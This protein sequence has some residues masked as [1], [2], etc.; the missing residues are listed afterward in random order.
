[1]FVPPPKNPP[2]GPEAASV[3]VSTK[4]II[5][6]Q[7]ITVIDHLSQEQGIPATEHL[8][9]EQSIPDTE[10]LSQ[11]QGIS[12]AEHLSQEQGI[13]T[14]SV[15]P[16]ERRSYSSVINNKRNSPDNVQ[17]SQKKKKVSLEE[18]NAAREVLAIAQTKAIKDKEEREKEEH[19]KKM[20]VY[21]EMLKAMKN[22]TVSINYVVNR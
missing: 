15:S 12:A 4:T 19:Q 9:Q 18:L 3:I 20:E 6:P 1:M 21:E 16:P 2:T 17:S 11:E 10:N 8:S 22:G 13:Q 5:P 14:T 7:G